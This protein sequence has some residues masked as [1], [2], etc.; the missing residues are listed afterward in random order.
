MHTLVVLDNRTFLVPTRHLPPKP[1][2]ADMFAEWE[3]PPE[4]AR[5]W[6]LTKL[7][8]GLQE[9]DRL[10]QQLGQ[11]L[12]GTPASSA[13]GDPHQAQAQLARALA[14]LKRRGGGDAVRKSWTGPQGERLA[15]AVDQALQQLD[16]A[17]LDEDDAGDA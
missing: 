16:R 5:D 10:G 12:T 14:G 4:Q 6:Q 13:P 7:S 9:L 3:V 17:D 2:E 11:A 1:W 8:A 15:Q